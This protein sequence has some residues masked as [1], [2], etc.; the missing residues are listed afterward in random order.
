MFL[1]INV[2]CAVMICLTNSYHF[3]SNYN[4]NPVTWPVA[5][6][7]AMSMSIRLRQRNIFINQY[8]MCCDN[9]F[10]QLVAKPLSH[11]PLSQRPSTLQ[12]NNLQFIVLWEPALLKPTVFNPTPLKT[13]AL[14]A[15]AL[16]VYALQAYANQANHIQVQVK[17]L[18]A[19]AIFCWAL[20]KLTCICHT[21]IQTENKKLYSWTINTYSI[22]YFSMTN[23]IQFN[24][25]VYLSYRNTDIKV[26]KCIPVQ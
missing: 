20:F 14:Q 8:C 23:T 12:P 4:I 18:Q 13:V 1:S 17:A 11:C 9:L 5:V 16:E 26:K 2:A 6:V 21:R 25:K 3:K 7:A 15:H 24:L 19:N 22:V 10:Y